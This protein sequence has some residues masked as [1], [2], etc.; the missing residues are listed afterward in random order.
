MND[1]DDWRCGPNIGRNTHTKWFR[2]P[3]YDDEDN[4]PMTDDLIDWME[5]EEPHEQ[6]EEPRV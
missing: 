2:A 1:R 3:I 4:A 6:H 5:R